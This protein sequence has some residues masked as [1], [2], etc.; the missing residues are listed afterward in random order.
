M[1]K[2]TKLK[3]AKKLTKRDVISSGMSECRVISVTKTSDG[4]IKVVA[5]NGYNHTMPRNTW[6]SVIK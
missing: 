4:R 5:T 1:A 6:V 3:Q 2:E